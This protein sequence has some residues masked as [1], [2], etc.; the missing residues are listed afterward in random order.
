MAG[1]YPGI[2]TITKEK[3]HEYVKKSGWPAA[4]VLLEDVARAAG[5]PESLLEAFRQTGEPDL[6]EREGPLADPSPV[7]TR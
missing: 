4:P 6:H 5:A 7:A 1:A 2:E 3:L